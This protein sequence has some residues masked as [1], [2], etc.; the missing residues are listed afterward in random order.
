[1]RKATLTR[2]ETGPEGTFGALVT[3]NG[4]TCRSLELPYR[5]NKRGVSCVPVGRY[6]F[7]WRTDSPKHGACYEEW[8]DPATPAREDVEGR[9]NV[10][11]HAA[12]LAGDAEAGFVAQL[13]GC[14]SLGHMVE[15]FPAKVHPAG[16][17]AQRGITG[18]KA[19]VAAFVA[20]MG[21]ETFELTIC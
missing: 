11:I 1:M 20:H 5:D 9:D 18:S 2:N 14:I 10:Q 19:T 21:Q 4:F 6:L 13:L 7:K 12:N 15:T 8:D 3:D 16:E 17:K